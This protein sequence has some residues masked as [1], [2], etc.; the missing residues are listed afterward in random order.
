MT[1]TPAEQAPTLAVGAL[2][3]VLHSL[4]AAIAEHLDVPL[5]DSRDDDATAYALIRRRADEAR[6]MATSA[7]TSP[8]VDD[9]DRIAAQLRDWTTQS[10]VTYR[11]WQDR[12]EQAVAEEQALLAE[13][14]TK[15]EAVR[16][17]VDR[18]FPVVAAFLAA[19]R[20]E[21]Q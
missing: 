8:N 19:E 12:T 1:G 20:G 3:P 13:P 2:P 14:A 9:L 11:S 10:P 21:G 4:L 6:I 15:T 18:A 7:L 16:R 5:A 17:S